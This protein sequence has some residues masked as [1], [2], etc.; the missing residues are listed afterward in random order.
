MRFVWWKKRKSPLVAGVDIG[1]SSVKVVELKKKGK[2]LVLLGAGAADLESGA[3]VDGDIRNAKAVSAAVARLLEEQGVSARDV[4][5]S[6]PGSA[7]MAKR[8]AIPAAEGDALTQAILAE[9]QRQLPSDISELNIDYQVLGP[10][11]APKTLDAMLVAVRRETIGH[12]AE[13]LAAAGRNPVLVDVD[14]FAVQNAFEEAYR[15]AAGKTVAL[16]NLGAS[17]INVN[18]VRD[19]VPLFTRDIPADAQYTAALQKSLDMRVGEAEALKRGKDGAAVTETFLGAIEPARQAFFDAL[20]VELHRTLSYLRQVVGPASSTD[21]D[22]AYVSGGLACLPGLCER[23]H[24][25]L[26]AP[27]EML[28]PLRGMHIS[29]AGLD[30]GHLAEISP[31]LAVAVGLALRSFDEE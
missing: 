14:A 9:A 22:A 17:L 28:D 27:A 3:V 19:T 30:A 18:I 20:A 2:S 13:V 6:V 1:S 29:E 8:I 16:L 31:R 24:D 11:T 5:T 12:R 23:L 7:V 25:E 4:A 26:N 15:P 21:I 10:G